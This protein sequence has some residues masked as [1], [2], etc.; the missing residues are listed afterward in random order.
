MHL[1]LEKLI[2][3]L[4]HVAQLDNILNILHWDE[5]VNLPPNSATGRAEQI[6]ALTEIA[7]REFTDPT[8]GELLEELNA[9]PDESFSLPEKTIIRE[10]RRDYLRAI[11]LPATFVAEKKTAESIGY[12]A[13]VKARESNDFSLFVP[14]LEELLDLSK[15]EAAFVDPRI[16]AYDYHIDLHDQGLDAK[17]IQQLFIELKKDLLPLVKTIL[18]SSHK[19]RASILKNFP[20]ETQKSFAL[21][22][23]Q[24]LGFDFSQGRL[25]V[26]VHPFC[27]GHSGDRR[28]TTRFNENVPLDSLFSTIHEVGH[29]LY[30]QGFAPENYGTPLGQ[31]VGM[32][33][34][35]SQ[36][37]LWENQ[38]G[39]SRAFWKFFE[40]L[41]RQQF[42]N[43]LSSIDSEAFYKV[44]NAVELNPIR[45]DSDEV[46]YNLHI[47][48][49]FGLEKE[50]FEGTV[51]VKDLRE[52]WNQKSKELLQLTPKNDKEGV[53]QDIHWSGA[54]FGYFPSYTLGNMIAAQLWEVAKKTIPSLE[55]SFE[56]GDFTPLLNWLRESIHQ[57]G[58]QYRTQGLVQKVTGSSI[59]TKPLIN[60]LKERYLPLYGGK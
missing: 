7:H 29:A 17:I 32:A 6:K 2:Q 27:S 47:I 33:V 59:S 44:I 42:P 22:V 23:A 52:A 21:L 55:T 41:Y 54:A 37:R 40:P 24:K 58:K 46:T 53:L 16:Q 5:K 50:L 18:A 11:K 45:V 49:R 34:H 9:L 39:R 10:T 13:W 15:Q 14:I 12:H 3:R 38:V 35:E 43:A 57:F 48:L 28:I 19:P 51:A 26:S 36:S 31:A 30:E 56:K 20:I 1:S 4:K 25:D 60:Y 8:I